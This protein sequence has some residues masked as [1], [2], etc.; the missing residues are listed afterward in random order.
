MTELIGLNRY[1]HDFTA[2][3]WV[4]GC[5]L[6][7]LLLREARGL[8]A[9]TDARSAVLRVAGKLRAVTVP[10]LAVSWATGGVRAATFARYEHVGDITAATV[11]MLVAKH[12]VFTALVAWGLWVHWQARG[13]QQRP[14]DAA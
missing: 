14:H 1:L 11:A 12:V 9:A 6:M 8:G 5:I 3:M 7:W 2:A 13:V 10:S 4:C